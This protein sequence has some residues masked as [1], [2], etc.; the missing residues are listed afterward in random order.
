MGVELELV[1]GLPVEPEA[2]GL[3]PARQKNRETLIRR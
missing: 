1:T 3:A 2:I